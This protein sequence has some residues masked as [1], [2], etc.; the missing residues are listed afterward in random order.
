MESFDE[1]TEKGYITLKEAAVLSNYSSDY[2]GQLIRSG[3]LEGKQVYSNIAWVTTEDALYDYMKNKGKSQSTEETKG[4]VDLVD[5]MQSPLF[6]QLLRVVIVFAAALLIV[7]FFILSV[8]ID[9]TLL[10]A[11]I[12][13]SPPGFVYE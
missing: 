6:K 3:K 2:I 13:E 1:A 4:S 9:R 11:E 10:S 5:V 12:E 8:G 7:A